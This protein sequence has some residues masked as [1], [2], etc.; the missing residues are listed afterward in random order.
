MPAVPPGP[1]TVIQVYTPFFVGTL[2]NIFLYAG[3][4]SWMRLLVLYLFVVET[5]NSFLDIGLIFEPLLLNFGN[6]DVV[7]T[8][9][10]TLRL[11]GLTTTLISTPVQIFMAWRINVIMETVI[12]SVIICILAM[13]SLAGSVWLAIAV[14]ASP[15]YVKFN[16]FRGAPSLWLISSAVA[17]IA[18]ACFLVISLSRKRT[19]FAVLNDQIDRII[20]V[21]VQTGSLTALTA[22]I[23]VIVFLSVPVSISSEQFFPFVDGCHHRT[24]RSF[25]L[26]I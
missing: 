14:S 23:D 21:T 5:A 16:D 19:G 22:L 25:L 18:I 9:P 6:M 7:A 13:S 17:D 24:P 10:W 3:D 26:G 11:D 12:P 8:S 4:K 1:P 2:L 15:Q 20:R